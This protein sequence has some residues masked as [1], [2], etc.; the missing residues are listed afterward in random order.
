MDFNEIVRNG[1]PFPR[2]H[3][4]SLM[5]E[6]TLACL[7]E[8]ARAAGLSQADINRLVAR[9][10][11]AGPGRYRQ[12]DYSPIGGL[13][14][15][16]KQFKPT[17]GIFDRVMLG[18]DAT[19]GNDW[20]SGLRV[21]AELDGEGRYRVTGIF[22]GLIRWENSGTDI[23]E[24]MVRAA[25]EAWAGIGRTLSPLDRD[26]AGDH[27]WGIHWKP[28]EL[29]AD[30]ADE[31]ARTIGSLMAALLGPL[32][33]RNEWRHSPPG[34]VLFP[35]FEAVDIRTEEAFGAAP[36]SGGYQFNFRMHESRLLAPAGRQLEA[37]VLGRPV[38]FRLG[39]GASGVRYSTSCEGG[40]GSIREVGLALGVQHGDHARFTLQP[41]G[42][43]VV[44]RADPPGILVKLGTV[45][46]GL[47]GRATLDALAAYLRDHP[48]VWF[49]VRNPTAI[50]ESRLQEYRS[51]LQ[52][53]LPVRVYLSAGISAG[54]TGNVV[55]VARLA[56]AQSGPAE[57]DA[58]GTEVVPQLAAIG[59][60]KVWLRLTD[61]QPEEIPLTEFILEDSGKPV[62]R[63]LRSPMVY[64]YR[65]GCTGKGHTTARAPLELVGSSR[66]T[67]DYFDDMQA[68]IEQ[69]GACM[70]LW[71]LG[72]RQTYRERLEQGPFWLNIYKAGADQTITHRCLVE[73]VYST[74]DP[75][76]MESPEPG[77]TLHHE[78]GQRQVNGLTA[79]TWFKITAF[80]ELLQPVPLTAFSDYDSGDPIV[81]SALRSSI[82]YA[83]R[84]SE[85]GPESV[86]GGTESGESMRVHSLDEILDAFDQSDLVFDPSDLINLH[87]A[88]HAL[89]AK[90]FVIL[91]GVS[92]TGK[93][94]FAQ[95]YA[96]ALYGRSPLTEPGNPYYRIVSVQPTWQDRT[97][98]LGYYNPL[99]E[100]YEV[101]G[102]LSHLLKAA[103]NPEHLY[104]VC[105]DEMNLAVVEHYF[106]DFL[107]AWES[108]EPIELHHHAGKVANV[109][110]VLP[111]PDN[112][113]VIGTVNV[114]ETT[115]GFSPKVLDR[116]YTVELTHVDVKRFG[117][118]FMQRPE[119]ASHR[120][121]LEPAVTLLD[122]A[123]RILEPHG[124]HFAYRTVSEILSFLLANSRSTR[125][126]ETNA[127]L[128]LMLC[129]KVLPKLRGDDRLLPM[130]QKFDQLVRE[131]LGDGGFR[132]P[133]VMARLID[134]ARRF[135]TFQYWR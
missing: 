62:E 130:L 89:P 114:D 10:A 78:K 39:Q 85:P 87:H 116:A 126:L 100:V 47:D 121:A 106:A 86:E 19:G 104:V 131:R 23:E 20:L 68:F 60:C 96:N 61:L 99:S 17:S 93:S 95:A 108:R 70:Y 13:T 133:K 58:P 35:R 30:A 113:L 14:L 64:V 66:E 28:H 16:Y 120:G 8:A 59:P 43:W 103:R 128:D 44:E 132:A 129:Q 52:R 98:L 80:E 15:F 9:G 46:A 112:L 55:Y 2:D 122:E 92:G 7:A 124:L 12:S 91:H 83:R 105:L 118:H 34:V 72:I 29:E 79:R 42:R 56:A 75:E 54:G 90:H 67:D 101:P 31:L 135:G 84:R 53:D 119:A 1:F 71:S 94:Q 88:L 25:E 134:D 22:V 6:F 37:V 111:V 110:E 97:A 81:P 117:E 50:R 109:P 18:T 45:E 49:G 102:F 11:L 76:G 27:M 5:R 73:R 125:R 82:A 33:Q 74:D 63:G 115:H 41:D 21:N 69:Q 65:I 51:A 36:T 107:S 38:T 26:E 3:M 4:I 48:A 123:N 127:A 24:P 40:F 77:Y 57:M 32:R